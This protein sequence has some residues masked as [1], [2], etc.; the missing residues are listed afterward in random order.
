M[1]DDV[2]DGGADAVGVTLVVE[3]RG[4]AAV[5]DGVVVDPLVD[6]GGGH[7]RGDTLADHV[8]H[9]D[10][11]CRGAL[12]ALDVRGGLEQAAGHNLLALGRQAVEPLVER[13][14]A[15]LVLL[16]GAAP[17]EVV[18]AGHDIVVIHG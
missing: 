17:A 6:L 4:D 11:D 8:E 16:S 2:V 18:A 7:A 5:L 13:G 1:A 9:A 12:D 14:V 3:V 10:V 15:F